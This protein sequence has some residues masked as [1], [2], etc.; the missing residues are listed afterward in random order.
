VVRGKLV[1][2]PA[3]DKIVASHRRAGGTFR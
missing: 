2:K 1:P 3:I